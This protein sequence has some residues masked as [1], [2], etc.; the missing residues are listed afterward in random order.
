MMGVVAASKIA[1]SAAQ[2]VAERHRVVPSHRA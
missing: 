2:A 1:E